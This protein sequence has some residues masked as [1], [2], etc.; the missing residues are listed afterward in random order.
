[1]INQKKINKKYIVDLTEPEKEQLLQLINKGKTSARK[2]KHANILLLADTDRTDAEI[3]E[4]LQTSIPTVERTRRRFV[5]GGLD[6]AINELPRPGR[7]PVLDGQGEAHLIAITCSEPP[8]GRKCW[9][10]QLLADRLVQLEVVDSIS[11]ETV[12][13]TLKKNEL[14]PW[15]RKQW[16]IPPEQNA[17]FVWRMEDVLSVYTRPYHLLR[18]MICMDETSKQLIAETRIPLEVEVGKVQRY[19]YEYERNGVCNLFMFFE[20]LAG[21]RHVLVTDRRTKR[22]WAYCIA[23][24][25]EVRYPQA[26]KIVL[27]MDN[28]NTHTPASLYEVFEPHYA[29][30][31]ADKLEIHYTP[32]HGSWLNM[33]EIEF[34]ILF[35]QCLDRRIPSKDR[36]EQEVSSWLENRNQ[37]QST[38]DWQFTTDDARIKLKRLYPKITHQN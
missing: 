22:D 3:A 15:L 4:T 37:K 5:E 19:D 34:S 8:E 12:R 10:L 21:K 30:F 25:I 29:K 7:N 20:P 28:L 1:M 14:K 31:L 17:S 36:V 27:V 18:P 33:A 13:T 26:E 11:K 38:V 6:F 9:T 23:D 16:C 2:V 32:K 35:Q 24:L